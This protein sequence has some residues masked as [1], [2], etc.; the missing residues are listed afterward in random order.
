VTR[1]IDQL[2]APVRP[3]LLVLFGTVV[4]VL[5]IACAN[6]ANLLLA[7]STNR[8]RE[9]SI[10]AALGGSRSRLV[11]QMLTETL[12]LALAGG[13]AAIVIAYGSIALIEALSVVNALVWLLTGTTAILP[14]VDQVSIDVRVLLFAAGHRLPPD[15]SAALRQSCMLRRSIRSA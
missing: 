2:V 8:E 13:L 7:R 4:F 14:R 3:A 9:I 5:L 6:V 15:C 11:R 1:V 12:V 10:R